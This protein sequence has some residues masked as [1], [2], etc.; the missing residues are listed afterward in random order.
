MK[1]TH[2]CASLGRGDQAGWLASDCLNGSPHARLR[3]ESACGLSWVRGNQSIDLI[4]CS[5][6][7]QSTAKSGRK[8]DRLVS[9]SA[10]LAGSRQ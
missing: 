1:H 4:T 10:S 6:Q 7:G 3:V 8:Q 5:E 2:Y 9:R